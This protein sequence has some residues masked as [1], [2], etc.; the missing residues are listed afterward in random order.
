MTITGLTSS[1]AKR[2]CGYLV[3]GGLLIGMTSVAT[4]PNAWAAGLNFG[5][6]VV[7][8][9]ATGAAV[10]SMTS[11]DFNN[12]GRADLATAEAIGSDRQLQILLAEEGGGFQ[13][14]QTIPSVTGEYRMTAGDLNG[15]GYSDLV[16]GTIN[17]TITDATITVFYG[18]STGELVDRQ[19]FTVSGGVAANT[20]WAPALADLDGDGVLDVVTAG[21][22]DDKITAW[23]NDGAGQFSSPASYATSSG[24]KPYWM[25]AGDFDGDGDQDVVAGSNPD[26]NSPGVEVWLNDGD[27]VLAGGI[28]TVTD[29]GSSNVL[30]DFTNDGMLDIF[31]GYD[32]NYQLLAGNGDGTFTASTWQDLGIPASVATAADFNYDG[33]LDIAGSHPDVSTVEFALGNGDGT[34]TASSTTV[35]AATTVR[36]LIAG[37]FGSSTSDLAVSGNQGAVTVAAN[38]TPHPP[39]AT[40]ISP[41]Q[42]GTSGGTAITI[43]GTELAN[44]T[45]SVGGLPCTEVVVNDSGTS[46]SCRTP[47]HAAGPAAVVVTTPYGTATVP[48]GFRYEDSEQI[49]APHRPRALRVKGGPSAS[50]YV[51]SWKAPLDASGDR[52]T[53]RYRLVLRGKKSQLVVRKH[54]NASRH[55]YT[56][57]RSFLLRHGVRSRGDV[58]G[59]LPF[60]VRVAAVN[61]AGTS[62]TSHARF[63]VQR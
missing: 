10:N 15:D 18:S 46:L 22:R 21:N 48:G 23:I 63:F 11:G 36:Q 24:L 55:S 30:G 4:V 17:G 26:S 53:T 13:V 40:A 3:V 38:N 8:P 50:K 25:G 9:L 41:T 54:L 1:P 31:R 45:V 58:R 42:G 57:T 5:T 39:T 62:P 6:P 35:T 7:Y 51:V 20:Q 34:F 32:T 33:K 52:P 16:L 47:A 37:P 61:S 56:F 29:P 28:M 60:K 59:I 43:T 27:G 12:D 19:D 2:T 49:A 44:A 14:N